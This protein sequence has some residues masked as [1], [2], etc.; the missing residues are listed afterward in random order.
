MNE[1][2]T[3]RAVAYVVEAPDPEGGSASARAAAVLEA[4]QSL[5]RAG[6]AL[7]LTEPGDVVVRTQDEMPRPWWRSRRRRSMNN[8]QVTDSAGRNET[9]CAGC[10]TI[11]LSHLSFDV[12]EPVVGWLAFFAERGIE[13]AR[14]DIGRPCVPREMFGKL[15]AERQVE[16]AA[17]RARRE[18]ELAARKVPASAG[19]PAV[20]GT[21]YEA[22]VAAGGVVMPSEE[23]GTGRVSPHQEFLDQQL[24][25]GQRLAADARAEA[26]AVAKAKKI[27]EESAKDALGGRPKK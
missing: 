10:R 23:F 20:D 2:P 3:E 25:E 21:P 17:S 14:D 4:M 27:L 22:M 11:P 19:V 12:N 5:Q 9:L 16:T 15:L 18:A 1:T 26:E 24:A 13:V 8:E 7:V 6:F